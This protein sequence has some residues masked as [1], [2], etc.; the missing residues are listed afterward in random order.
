MLNRIQQAFP[1]ELSDIDFARLLIFRADDPDFGV[2]PDLLADGLLTGLC[3][4]TAVAG[5]EDGAI[6]AFDE[7]ENQLHP[8]A[9]RTLLAAMEEQAASR[10][11]TLLVTTHSP[12]VLS[13]FK[14]TESHIYVVEPGV[15]ATSDILPLDEARSPRFLA[16]FDP[17]DLYVAE[18]IAA[19][20]VDCRPR[21]SD[22]EE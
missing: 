11:L 19:Q 20:S 17:G 7:L 8:H 13:H 9:I 10:G 18:D 16:H 22:E 12:V 14:N 21:V 5:A 6:V 1:G 15:S 3:H 4:L 2:P